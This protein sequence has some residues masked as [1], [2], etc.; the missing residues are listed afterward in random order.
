MRLF[1]ADGKEWIAQ[2]HDSATHQKTNV[3]VRAGWEVVQ[4][5]TQPPGNIQRVTFRPPGW[6]KNASIAELIEALRE[7]ESVR[8]TWQE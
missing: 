3:T 2:I 8:A 1:H 7:G 5:D 6:L 4:F